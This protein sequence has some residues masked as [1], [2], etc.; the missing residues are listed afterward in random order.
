MLL[1]VRRD[2]RAERHDLESLLFRIGERGR[3]ERRAEA[4]AFAHG[5]DLRMRERDAITATVVGRKSDGPVSEHGEIALVLL[6]V[7]DLEIARLGLDGLS[8]PIEPEPLDELP[9]RVRAARIDV[10]AVALPMTVA[11]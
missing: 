2:E 10:G 7:H 11:P 6:V 9:R 5:I 4:P 1:D 3:D 8:R